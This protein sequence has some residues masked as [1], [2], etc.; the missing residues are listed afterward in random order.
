MLMFTEI[1]VAACAFV[2]QE[3]LAGSTAARASIMLPA[4]AVL[5]NLYLNVISYTLWV[6]V[7]GLQLL[8]PGNVPFHLLQH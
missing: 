5:K 1:L 8:A 2:A 7:M 6:D 4:A 3:K